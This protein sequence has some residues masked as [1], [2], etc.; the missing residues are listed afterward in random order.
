MTG[1][2]GNNPGPSRLAAQYLRMSTDHQRYSLQNQ[3]AA[4]AG[5]ATARNYRV[6]RTYADEGVSGLQACNRR[7]LQALLQD[8]V[9][10]AAAFETI[11][12][13]DVSRWGRFQNPDEAAYYEFL[14]A[15]AGVAVEY[16]AEPFENDESLGAA[17]LKTVKRAMAAEFSRQ[18]SCRVIEAQRVLSSGGWWLQGQPGLGL[19]RQ[20]VSA[21]GV[22]LK[23]LERGQR[24]ASQ[25][26][27]S[28][29][30]PGP[31]AEVAVIERIFRLFAE[32][33]V[34]EAAIVRL[35]NAEGVRAEHGAAWTFKRVHSI[36]LNPKYVGDLRYN[37]SH[38][39]LGG[40]RVSHPRIAWRVVSAAH[41]PI[42]PRDLFDAAQARLHA[43]TIRRTTDE[44]CANL[45]RLLAEH[46]RLNE[47]I[48]GTCG[49]EPGLGLGAYRNR[50]GSVRAAYAAI[51]YCVRSNRRHCPHLSDKALLRRIA[52]LLEMEGYLSGKLISRTDGLPRREVVA[53]RFGGLARVY[54]LVGYD[55][56]RG[57]RRRQ[58]DLAQAC[59]SVLGPAPC[60]PALGD[61][62]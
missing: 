43:R 29:L 18:L 53:R 55:A 26:H 56:P 60:P 16:C 33:G 15:Q 37:T 41:P 7:G 50:F 5:F 48:I 11:L 19:R 54:E 17:L 24:K 27:R 9:S 47:K 59:G 42:V 35:L 8:A 39:I 21:S 10:G 62:S 49:V 58:N 30:T 12:V 36:L 1:A 52:K 38:Q 57:E 34:T 20:V 6:V 45:R 44:L 4:I 32:A 61:P 13:Y 31:A 23:V 51:G 22:R 3:A 40:R 46:G 2:A 28:R 25:Q 14:C